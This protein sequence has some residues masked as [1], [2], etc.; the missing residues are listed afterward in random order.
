MGGYFKFIGVIEIIGWIIGFI[1]FGIGLHN[2]FQSGMNLI[3]IYFIIAL[4]CYIIFGPAF[5][6]A[7]YQ[8]G[9][10]VQEHRE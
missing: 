7:F 1:P 3:S 8:L 6:L 9:N 4:V 5:G 2:Q 10:L